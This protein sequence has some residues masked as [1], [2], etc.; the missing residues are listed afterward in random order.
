MSRQK[1]ATALSLVTLLV[2][3]VFSQSS[4][5]RAAPPVI[6]DW[7]CFPTCSATDDK[8]LTITASGSAL[9]PTSM[10]F[11]V[12]SAP[13]SA[14]VNLGVFDADARGASASWDDG[15]ATNNS[16]VLKYELIADPVGNGTGSTVV[17]GFIG[18]FPFFT[19]LA[20]V[21]IPGNIQGDDAW[22][23]FSVSNATSGA[24]GVD[25]AYHYLWR[26]TSTGLNAGGTA[27]IANNQFKLRTDGTIALTPAPF[28]FIAPLHNSIDI[29]RVYPN[30]GGSVSGNLSGTTY[31]G[32]WN[33]A[34]DVRSA[35]S[36][37]AIWDGDLDFGNR[38]CTKA[39][40]TD[41]PD[42]NYTITPNTLPF[43][44]PFPAT[45]HIEGVATGGSPCASGTGIGS[46]TGN[47]AD[48]AYSVALPAGSVRDTALAL[49]RYPTAAFGLDGGGNPY[50]N[51]VY[52]LIDRKGVEYKN[53][54]PSG[55]VEWEQ[56]SL[57]TNVGAA[58]DF[59][60]ASIE[61]GVWRL[62][63]DGQDLGNLSNWFYPAKMIGFTPKGGPTPEDAFYTLDG[64]VFSDSNSNGSYDVGEPLI[65]NATLTVRDV[66]D[67]IVAT[68][69]ADSAGAYAFRV[70]SGS[71]TVTI[72]ASNTFLVG[73]GS[74]TGGNTTGLLTVGPPSAA[75]H[76]FGYVPN[77]PPTAVND[78]TTVICG[79]SVVIPVL[80]NDFD[81][82]GDSILF[83]SFASLPASG[84]VAVNAGLVT[85]TAAGSGCPASVTFDYTIT[86]SAHSGVST[87][88]V[89][90]TITPATIPVI[91]TIPP[92][93]EPYNRNPHPAV[94]TVTAAD[95]LNITLPV[96][97][98]GVAPTVYGPSTTAPTN[99]GTY[100]TTCDYA[101]DPGHDP[102][103]GGPSTVK[104]TPVALTVV[105]NNK[106]RA[107]GAANPLLDGAL[108]GVLA[109]DNITASY[110]TT[111]N[112]TTPAAVYPGLIVASLNDPS[113]L[114]SNYTVSNTPGTLTITKLPVII[115][116]PPVDEPYNR[117]PHPAVCTV[118]SADGLNI[119]LPVTYTG[120]A[121]T[122]YG[123][124]TTAPTNVGTYSTTCDYAGDPGHDPQ[125]GGPS[126]VKITPV[127][128]TVVAN[129]KTRAYGAANPLLDG[130]LTGVLSGDGITA[131]YSTI[132]NATTPAG[133]YPGLIIATFNDPNA[134]LGNY[135][136]TNTPGTLTI[137]KVTPTATATGGT[138]TYDTNP[139]GGT[140]TIS[141]GLTGVLSYTPGGSTV[142]VNVGTYTVNCDYAGD[143]NHDPAHATAT[144]RINP[145]AAT[146][147]AG[148]GTKVYGTADPSLSAIGTSGFTGSD[149]SGI[150]LAQSRVAGENV[151]SY[152]VNATAT[153]GNS[154]NYT[155]TYT[156]GA[157][158]ITKVT[159]TA[160][161]TGG[162][163]TYDTNPHPGTCTISGGLTGVLTYTPGGTS[164]PVAVGTYTVNCNYAGDA[165]HNP[166]SATAT[167][168]I[169]QA[170]MIGPR[171]TGGGTIGD[172][173]FTATV[174]HGFELHCDVNDGPN[175]LE[176]N[177]NSG[178]RFHLEKLQ[179]ASCTTDPTIKQA[180]PAAPFNTYTGTGWGYYNG[181]VKVNAKWVF[182]DAGEPG[183]KDW[184]TLTLTNATTGQVVL[185][186]TG[187]LV[188][189][190]QQAHK[191]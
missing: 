18:A 98:T 45:I 62:R 75:T 2:L 139:H 117:N 108:T 103:P 129:N 56:F 46:A 182:T 31:D 152:A 80:T 106:T 25:G 72:D 133:V 52:K 157:F 49:T 177:W 134:T 101:G 37:L 77:R 170:T 86:D 32:I 78:A 15:N 114:L 65:P 151:G 140:C 84:S 55:Q 127:A 13:G 191:N 87:A 83:V 63:L 181:T 30:S 111:A 3:A 155:I 94:C 174:T 11:A 41:D 163:F 154:G 118:T 73:M 180:P 61:T 156:A 53:V 82:D 92:V 95:G 144:V 6:T 38:D 135:T 113:S 74:S 22:T 173:R 147:T 162:T 76:N 187:N 91:V 34:F 128:L 184:A 16:P 116:I 123:P 136:V 4:A 143:P 150:T 40:D 166:A 146:V 88:T 54:N 165:N 175:N 160:T 85:Y 21:V 137:T 36:K 121:P 28:A 27:A 186:T 159:P 164:A 93:E 110:S 104:I 9:S 124:S 178:E 26:I 171:M 58:A 131:G 5:L 132:A 79:A 142:P 14:S 130:T 126:T 81:P 105:A 158:T 66:F 69:T 50:T 149:L 183:T 90:V 89:T 1:I 42:T 188:K 176:V 57:D 190:N 120:V 44:P 167:I 107:Y 179:T 97:Y 122:V 48:D 112:A 68:G 138:F 141:D 29:G 24:L 102:Q 153:G 115:T 8:F 148:G 185:T 64:L 100:S 51:V 161:A 39:Q 145:K 96:T 33:F 125:P 12:H 10:L 17:G 47:P 19:D 70:A 35:Q 59:H 168:T 189:G 109:G 169:V 119:T 60:P 23:D 99:V 7:V 71:Y 43:T 67:E 172:K 20:G